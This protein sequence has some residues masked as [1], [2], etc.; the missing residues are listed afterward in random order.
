MVDIN[1]R[2]I[3]SKVNFYKNLKFSP[4]LLINLIWWLRNSLKFER[5]SYLFQAL[6]RNYAKQTLLFQ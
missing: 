4:T 6:R 5:F 3:T 1:C 2:V